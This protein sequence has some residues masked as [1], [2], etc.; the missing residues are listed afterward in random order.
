MYV[1]VCVCV[2]ACVCMHVCMYVC[3]CACT[4]VCMY[5][6][7]YVC[8]VLAAEKRIPLFFFSLTYSAF[9]CCSFFSKIYR[10][11]H[12]F[13]RFIVY[14]IFF[15]RFIVYPIFFSDYRLSI[16]VPKKYYLKCR[17]QS[18]KPISLVIFFC[19]FVPLTACL[20]YIHS[21]Y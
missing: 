14:P 3:L 18:S 13:H 15:H 4:Y 11:S 6:C 21:S 1:C 20:S 8:I 12:F 17:H 7:M 10:L 16:R 5:V 19:V 2:Y 9:R